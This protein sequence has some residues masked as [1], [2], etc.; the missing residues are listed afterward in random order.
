MR[1]G[2]PYKEE[3][4]YRPHNTVQI[5]PQNK[6]TMFLMF[7]TRH[8]HDQPD[9]SLIRVK[10]SPEYVYVNQPKVV[11]QPVMYPV[12]R[13]P[14]SVSSYT[15]PKVK[16]VRSPSDVA[17]SPSVRRINVPKRSKYVLLEF[18]I[19]IPLLLINNIR[20]RYN[21][22]NLRRQKNFANWR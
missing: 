7:T 5:I 11:S 20:F 3:R 9:G 8:K 13:Y 4:Y 18:R 2:A 22:L 21:T 17:S 12:R 1:P 16:V 6:L 14:S 10:K 19:L 15:Q